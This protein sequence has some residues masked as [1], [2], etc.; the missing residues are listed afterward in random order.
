MPHSKTPKARANAILRMSSRNPCA[1]TRTAAELAKNASDGIRLIV[2]TD[3][4]AADV[5]AI[6]Q[7][8]LIDGRNAHRLAAK[9]TGPPKVQ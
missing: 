8:T 6:A 2:R 7:K 9:S 1:V 4:T 5:H 3:A